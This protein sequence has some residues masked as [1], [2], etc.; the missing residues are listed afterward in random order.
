MKNNVDA[1]EAG[2]STCHECT[3]KHEFENLHIRHCC[4]EKIICHEDGYEDK[5]MKQK[6][7]MRNNKKKVFNSINFDY[8][9]VAAEK[10]Q[11]EL[12]VEEQ[13]SKIKH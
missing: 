8:K 9:K 2:G 1:L 4:W 12:K 7:Y 11:L 10:N 5:K 13:Q 3:S 6:K